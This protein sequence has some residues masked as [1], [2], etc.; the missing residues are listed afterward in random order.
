MSEREWHY[1][2]VNRGR[3]LCSEHGGFCDSSDNY[4]GTCP[5]CLKKGEKS[6]L[7]KWSANKVD[8]GLQVVRNLQNRSKALLGFAS[9]LFGVFGVSVVAQQITSKGENPFAFLSSW[10]LCLLSASLFLWL[11]AFACLV[12]SLG[13]FSPTKGRVFDKQSLD[14]WD[15]SVADSLSRFECRQSWGVR[16]LSMSVFLL[17]MSLV[18]PAVEPILAWDKCWCLG[19]GSAS[20]SN[21]QEVSPEGARK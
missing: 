11:I 9:G 21:L 10:Q 8:R 2:E 4:A 18:L 17:A 5:I 13:N 14:K 6:D 19:G 20:L 3:Y 1:L 12:L 16:A 15:R 7:E